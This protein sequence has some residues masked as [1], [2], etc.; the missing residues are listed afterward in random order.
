MLDLDRAFRRFGFSCGQCNPPPAADFN[1]IMARAKIRMR[2]FFCPPGILLPSPRT[3][4]DK[5]GVYD[6]PKRGNC[7]QH[8][9]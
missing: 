5:G 9:D 8:N 3:W 1:T 4:A 7:L 2:A 6:H